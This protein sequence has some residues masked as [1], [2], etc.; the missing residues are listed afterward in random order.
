MRIKSFIAHTVQEALLTVKKEMGESSIIL[1]TRSIE[2]GDIKC[3]PGQRLI[4]VVAAENLVEQDTNE[5]LKGDSDLNNDSGVGGEETGTASHQPDK[6]EGDI[7]DLSDQQLV[8]LAATENL[9]EQDADEILKSDSVLNKDSGVGSEEEVTTFPQ[10]DKEEGEIKGLSDQ[11]QVEPATVENLT[12]QN[13][14]GILESNSDLNVDSD[15]DNEEKATP[16]SKINNGF[17]DGLSEISKLLYHKLRSQQVEREHAQVLIKE[18]LSGLDQDGVEMIDIQRQLL[19]EK[20]IGKIENAVSESTNGRTNKLMALVGATGVGKTT[21]ISKLASDARRRTDKEIILINVDDDS[22]EKLSKQA[23]MIGASVWVAPTRQELRKIIDDFGSTSH[24]FIDTPGIN[25]F[26]DVKLLEM[27]L[28][29]HNIPYLETHLVVSA[30]TRFTDVINIG[31]NFT[32]IPVQRFLF[33][34]IDETNAYGTLFS[35]A[36]ETEMPISYITDGQN[37]HENI[38]PAT[39][40]MIAK[41]ILG[42]C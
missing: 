26:D 2:E 27:K 18:V 32:T 33:T 21:T 23:E 12:E 4:E 35:A 41:M 13:T 38:K 36:I 37:I 8:E 20:I 11:Q 16:L 9:T 39:A 1:E 30:T 24:I 40:S 25:H 42:S 19:E 28:Y 3:I 34:K 10:P 31:K 22:A 29:L 5:I 6:E 14:D 17:E 15:V 7:K